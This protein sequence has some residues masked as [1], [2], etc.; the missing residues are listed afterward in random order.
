MNLGLL[1]CASI[2]GF[3]ILLMVSYGARLEYKIN[4]LERDKEK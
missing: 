4:K 2:A 3:T 1:I